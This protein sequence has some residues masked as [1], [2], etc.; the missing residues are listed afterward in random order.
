M[1]KITTYRSNSLNT[2]YNYRIY[3]NVDI[4]SP[5]ALIL[6]NEFLKK[7]DKDFIEK[8]NELQKYL[9]KRFIFLLR[10]KN[11][12]GDLVCEYCGKKHLEIGYK[13]IDLAYLN[14]KNK[15]LATIDHIIPRSNKKIDYLDTT[16]WCVSCESCNKK[17]SSKTVEEFKNKNNGSK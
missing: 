4:K 16:N 14:N 10:I 3:G 11:I 15:N 13:N 2:E 17:K 6:L 8:R 5:A 1:I 9:D 7:Q 12:T